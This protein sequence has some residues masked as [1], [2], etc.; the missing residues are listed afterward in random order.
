MKFSQD[1]DCKIFRPRDAENILGQ[2]PIPLDDITFAMW[3][4]TSVTLTKNH[5]KVIYENRTLPSR[6][7]R[8]VNAFTN[9]DQ[10]SHIL[11]FEDLSVHFIKNGKHIWTLEQSISQVKKVEIFAFARRENHTDGHKDRTGDDD[12]NSITFRLKYLKNMDNKMS[13][14]EIPVRIVSRYV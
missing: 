6:S 3:C 5:D 10:S 14:A 2:K 11:M 4:P 8:L 12:Q 9:R 7:G 13:F 1:N